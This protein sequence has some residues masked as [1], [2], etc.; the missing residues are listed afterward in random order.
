MSSERKSCIQKSKKGKIWSRERWRRIVGRNYVRKSLMYRAYSSFF[1]LKHKQFSLCNSNF[2][3]INFIEDSIGSYGINSIRVIARKKSNCP[4][5]LYVE[6]FKLIT[7][8][9]HS[10]IPKISEKKFH[11]LQ[12]RLLCFTLK[13]EV[14]WER[15]ALL[16]C[17]FRTLFNVAPPKKQDTKPCRNRRIKA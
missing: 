16:I 14:E 5:K 10:A 15:T 3:S 13:R 6:K 17:I 12:Y 7:G 4:M 8:K 1:P 11:T 2:E 9:Q